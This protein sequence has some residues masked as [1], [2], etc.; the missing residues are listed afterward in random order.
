MARLLGSRY[1]RRASDFYRYRDH[2]TFTPGTPSGGGAKPMLIGASQKD[3]DTLNTNAKTGGGH[4]MGI[5]RSYETSGWANTFSASVASG[6][7]GRGCASMWSFSDFSYVSTIASGSFNSNLTTFWNSIPAGHKFYAIFWHEADVHTSSFTLTDYKAAY[8]NLRSTLNASTADKSLVKL[9]GLLTSYGFR[10]G[11]GPS[12]FDAKHD[13]VGIDFYE[14]IRDPKD[15]VDTSS[16]KTT[17]F[18][19]PSYFVDDAA[20][21]AS[22]LGVPVIVG[23]YGAH[24]IKNAWT[25]QMTASTSYP[26]LSEQLRSFRLQ[27]AVDY[28]DGLNCAAFCYFHS[29]GGVSGPWWLDSYPVWSATATQ[30]HDDT[31]TLTQFKSIIANHATY[32]GS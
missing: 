15:P 11:N 22:S 14:Y 12:Y 13:F 20:T 10:Q 19:P 28:L 3:Y 9:G 32:T 31:D 2:A 27:Q 24:P 25:G 18:R 7:P 16:H 4:G 17:V 6:D 29:D 26:P 21:L 5:R 23:E 30:N 8:G 1:K